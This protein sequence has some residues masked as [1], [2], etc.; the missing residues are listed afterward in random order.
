MSQL[1][2]GLNGALYLS[3]MPLDGGVSTQP[4]NKAGAK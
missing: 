4:N 1:G 3:S 2:C